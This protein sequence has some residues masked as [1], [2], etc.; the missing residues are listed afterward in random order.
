MSF[1]RLRDGTLSLLRSSACGVARDS[2]IRKRR[3][4][5]ATT[6]RIAREEGLSVRQVC[7]ILARRP[8]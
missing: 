6:S 8:N 4:E 1:E 5:G 2:R 3:A 7:N